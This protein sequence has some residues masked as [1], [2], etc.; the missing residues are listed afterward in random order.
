MP[1]TARQSEL[2]K[3]G[4]LPNVILPLKTK[5]APTTMEA[6]SERFIVTLLGVRCLTVSR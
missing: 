1:V 3:A 4:K 5:N 2:T 6:V